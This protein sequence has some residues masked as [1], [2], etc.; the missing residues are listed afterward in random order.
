MQI[1]INGAILELEGSDE[2]TESTTYKDG[3]LLGVIVRRDSSFRATL[4]RVWPRAFSAPAGLPEIWAPFGVDAA[5]CE[6]IADGLRLLQSRVDALD[7]QQ[8][9][10]EFQRSLLSSWP[11]S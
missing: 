8:G 3:F 9:S 4:L 11:P 10:Y 6:T 1:L 7:D 5:V 2:I